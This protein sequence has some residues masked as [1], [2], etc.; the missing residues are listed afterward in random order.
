MDG[1]HGTELVEKQN[2]KRWD[3]TEQETYM[4]TIYELVG[5]FQRLGKETIAIRYLEEETIRAVTYGE[6][7]DEVSARAAALMGRGISGVHVGLIGENSYPWLCSWLGIICA[8]NVA[9]PVNKDMSAK[10]LAEAIGFGH[11]GYVICDREQRDVAGQAASMGWAKVIGMEEL[12][13]EGGCL[14]MPEKDP[15][16]VNQEPAC[17][18]F[19]SGTTGKSKGVLLS[20]GNLLA[21]ED[22]E[23]W[24]VKRQ[25]VFLG[26]PFH[27]VMMLESFINAL[28][29]RWTVD[30]GSNPKYFIRDLR[31]LQPTSLSVTPSLLK[32]L[33]KYMKR[34]KEGE[35]GRRL[36]YINCGG[37]RMEEAYF[38]FFSGRNVSL[39]QGYG[40]TESAGT[41]T[42]FTL[43]RENQTS[44]GK[45]GPGVEIA[46]ADGEL[47]L[48]SPGVMLGYYR[49]PEETAKVIKDGWLCSGD[50]GYQDEDGNIYITGRKKNLII[51]S[52]GENISPEELEGRLL[53]HPEIREIRIYAEKDRL[54]ADIFPDYEYG[55]G[56]NAEEIHQSIQRVMDEYNQSVATYRQ[57]HQIHIRETELEKTATHKIKR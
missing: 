53:L 35:L 17:M 55:N 6:L 29:F 22:V 8:G 9:V 50:L 1:L 54:C 34:P 31:K 16:L 49:E 7:Y 23:E 33:Y 11:I 27:H 24:R 19:T 52:N 14:K 43:T 40:M 44:V 28:K 4:K 39:R 5:E 37:T 51:L 57:I 42:S 25:E 41:G 21:I 18:L 46:F 45:P 30:V 15:D 20:H 38:D 32:L 47:L 13:E 36:D 26:L 56:L 12:Q 3:I 10:E 48:K 2:Q